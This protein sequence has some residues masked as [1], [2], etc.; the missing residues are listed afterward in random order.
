MPTL[1]S[2]FRTFVKTH[3]S[4]VVVPLLLLVLGLVAIIILFL[5][6]SELAPMIYTTDGWSFPTAMSRA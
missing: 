3:R 4:L 2:E 1:L 6:G 5:R